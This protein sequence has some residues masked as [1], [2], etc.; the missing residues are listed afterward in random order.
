MLADVQVEVPTAAEGATADAEVPVAAEDATA[1]AEA[2]L[3]AESTPGADAS[4]GAAEGTAEAD[5]PLQSEP[6]HAAD[7]AAEIVDAQAEADVS[8]TNVESKAPTRTEKRRQVAI[9]ALPVEAVAAKMK[10]LQE[11]ADQAEAQAKGLLALV[12]DRRAQIQKVSQEYARMQREVALA[13]LESAVRKKPPTAWMRFTNDMM[14]SVQGATSQLKLKKIAE[15]WTALGKEEKQKYVDEHAKEHR[16]YNEWANSE[17]GQRIVRERNEV[18]RQSR[19]S[20]LNHLAEATVAV[21]SVPREVSL[22]TPVKKRRSVPASVSP[23]GGGAFDEKVLEEARGIELEA[24][25][26][27]LASRPEIIALKKSAPELLDALKQNEG[28]VNAAKRALLA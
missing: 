1:E 7:A 2:P 16:I 23:T 9:K 14:Q 22:E 20:S 28:M 26:R 6:T 24:Q 13:N 4:A 27:N 19:A 3:A 8:T 5:V 15:L 21:G 10:R 12:A 17:E 25:L 18:L 11:E